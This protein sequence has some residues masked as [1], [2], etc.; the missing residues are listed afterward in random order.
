M[1]D[2]SAG[3]IDPIVKRLREIGKESPE[4]EEAALAYEA[5]LPL[6]R[7]TDLKVAP[8]GLTSGQARGKMEE[9]LHLLHGIGLEIDLHKARELMLLLAGALDKC[10]KNPHVRNVTMA[11]KKDILDVDVL[12]SETA[13]GQRESIDA[14]AEGLGI[15][16]N[17]LWTLS[18]FS[19]RPALQA[20]RIQLSPLVE[21]VAWNKGTCYVCG[22][23]A[24]LA[25]LQG[26]NQVKHLRCGQC[27]A[28]WHAR[29]LQCTRCGNEDHRT[30][31]YLSPA[32]KE[33]T[34][35]AEVCEKCRV[36]LKVIVSFSPSPAEM[37]SVEDLATVQ[38]DY[39]AQGRGYASAAM[40]SSC[41]V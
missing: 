24:L 31:G 4:L 16:P 41:R 34:M 30:L 1:S 3:G 14:V 11:L 21:G 17:L 10:V 13:A 2:R 36:Y 32:K 18:S 35:R 22:A 27:G 28:D 33:A 38:L 29:R 39:M 20:V 40:R 8:V 6:L 23:G 7:D 15:D 19:L 26:N 12:L 9:G 5:V 37:L 25:E